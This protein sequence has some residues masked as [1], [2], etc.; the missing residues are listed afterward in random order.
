MRLGG[1]GL[2]WTNPQRFAELCADTA[3]RDFDDHLPLRRRTFFDR[4]LIDVAAAIER[5]ELMAIESLSAALHSMRYAPLVFM[6]PPWK[7]RFRQDSERRHTFSD[8]LAEYDA[9]VPFYRRWGYDTVILPQT[10]VAERVAFV[11]S[12]LPT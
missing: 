1:N 7:T 5:Q 2:P 9:L 6:S 4:S 10:S 8:A 12:R 3:L 11:L